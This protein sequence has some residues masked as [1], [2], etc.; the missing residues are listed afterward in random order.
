MS[1]LLIVALLAGCSTV[2]MDPTKMS[3]EQL[4]AW[5]KDKNASA[6]CVSGKTATG[7]VTSTYVV[8]DKGT[9]ATGSVTVDADCKVTIQAGA[10]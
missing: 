2:A 3:A 10:K 6:V 9:V 4:E 1:R 7:N 5:A 8:L